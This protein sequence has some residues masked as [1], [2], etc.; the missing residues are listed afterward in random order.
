M[1]LYMLK[2]HSMSFS[3]EMPCY[4]SS[5]LL[6]NV[7]G[8]P[9]P[10]IRN[11]FAQLLSHLRVYVYVFFP[12]CLM[13]LFERFV[14]MSICVS[15]FICVS[16]CGFLGFSFQLPSAR[17]YP[18]SRRNDKGDGDGDGEAQEEQESEKHH[19]HDDMN[20]SNT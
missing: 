18:Y 8:A 9:G 3:Y 4:A 15:I 12:S 1:I 17:H 5:K 7:L 20:N 19:K 2:H 14:S 10:L 6:W 11:L 16:V 13:S